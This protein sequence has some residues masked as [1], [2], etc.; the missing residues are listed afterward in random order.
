M[1]VE[2]GEVLKCRSKSGFVSM[3]GALVILVTTPSAM[4]AHPMGNAKD[5]N[6]STSSTST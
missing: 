2:I 3:E 1:R 6:L 5:V 4:D